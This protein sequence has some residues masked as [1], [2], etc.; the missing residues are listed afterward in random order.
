MYTK[1]QEIKKEAALIMKSLSSSIMGVMMRSIPNCN[2]VVHR[3][4]EE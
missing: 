2:G 4:F 1:I 3:A